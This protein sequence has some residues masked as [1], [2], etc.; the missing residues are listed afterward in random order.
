MQCI[1]VLCLHSQG[2]LLAILGVVVTFTEM[3]AAAVDEDDQ[4]CNNYQTALSEMQTLRH[5]CKS[6]VT[7]DCC[8]VYNVL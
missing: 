7:T 4:A 2:F 5:R 1:I 3:G 8:K 6:A